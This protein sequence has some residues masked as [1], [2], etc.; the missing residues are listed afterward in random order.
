MWT[1]YVFSASRLAKFKTVFQ[2]F[3]IGSVMV[4]LAHRR[5]M[6]EYPENAYGWF[7]PIHDML[8]AVVIAIVVVLSIASA[9]EYIIKNLPV[10]LNN[11]RA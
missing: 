9:L 7:D 1:G 11:S 3:F 8:N 5:M 2:M 10:I 6:F 4:H